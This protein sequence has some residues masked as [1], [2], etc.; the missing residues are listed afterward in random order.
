[1]ANHRQQTQAK[2]ARERTVRE[3][4]ERKEEKKRAAAA[5]RK[6]RAQGIVPQEVTPEGIVPSEPEDL[7]T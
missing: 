3:R 2:A 7:A 1:M 4:R 5:E 6:E